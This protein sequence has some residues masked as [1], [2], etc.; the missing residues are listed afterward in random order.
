MTA[1]K[2][3]IRTPNKG[4]CRKQVLLNL[5]ELAKQSITGGQMVWSV[6]YRERDAE[7]HS[8]YLHQYEAV[9]RERGRVPGGKRALAETKGRKKLSRL[10]NLSIPGNSRKTLRAHTIVQVI[11]LSFQLQF[12]L[13][14]GLSFSHEALSCT[15]QT[16]MQITGMVTYVALLQWSKSNFIFKYRC[17]I[18]CHDKLERKRKTVHV[19]SLF[20]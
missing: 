3:V 13:F 16:I 5:H 11:E 4:Y 17:R 19:C 8:F 10:I 15:Q 12:P 2:V 7:R 6:L 18:I 14:S 1:Y 9:K 20:W